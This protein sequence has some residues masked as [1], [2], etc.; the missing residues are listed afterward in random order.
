MCYLDNKITFISRL[1][2][3]RFR[4]VYFPAAAET[5]LIEKEIPDISSFRRSRSIYALPVGPPGL[6]A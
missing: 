1:F 2:K 4:S 6:P 3:L 5:G